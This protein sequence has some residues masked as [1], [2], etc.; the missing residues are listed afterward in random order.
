MNMSVDER[1]AAGLEGLER[2]ERLLNA[3]NEQNWVRGIRA[4]LAELR[5]QDG[6]VNTAGFANARSIYRT[7]TTGGR[8]FSEYFIWNTDEEARLSANSEL[9]HL[10][11]RLWSLFSSEE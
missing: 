3:Q 11:E 1:A 6:S 2:L 7:M 10:R 8:G 4:A 5:K 9:D